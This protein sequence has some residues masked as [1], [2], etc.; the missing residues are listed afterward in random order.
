MSGNLFE[1]RKDWL[2]PPPNNTA[3]ATISKPPIKIEPQV[4][5]QPA[6][7]ATVP[8][9]AEQCGWGP[10]CPICKNI[11][12]WDGE[13]QKQIQQNTKNTQA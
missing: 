12:D 4:Q 9:R 10:N 3:N 6:P 2:I 13:H 8:P 7:S 1:L 5:E 11:E